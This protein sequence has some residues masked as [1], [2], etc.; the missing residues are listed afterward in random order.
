MS[1]NR[2]LKYKKKIGLSKKIKFGIEIEA[3]G[4]DFI[5]KLKERDDVHFYMHNPSY[6]PKD[7]Y[8]KNRWI[9]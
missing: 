4:T 8:G 2:K 6:K 1:L 9:L 5:R 3:L 7:I